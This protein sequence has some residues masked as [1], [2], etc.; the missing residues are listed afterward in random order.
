M[1]ARVGRQT[2]NVNPALLVVS[3]RGDSDW[4][5]YTT[6]VAISFHY[7]FGFTGSQVV[8]NTPSL[9]NNFGI[10]V[11]VTAAAAVVA[12]AGDTVVHSV[13][14]TAAAR[15]AAACGHNTATVAAIRAPVPT[16]ASRVLRRRALVVV[17][18]DVIPQS[19]FLS[20][21]DACWRI[22]ERLRARGVRRQE[23]QCRNAHPAPCR[24][25]NQRRRRARAARRAREL[26]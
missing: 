13:R 1:Y 5:M 26:E 24:C 16:C 15:I 18:C 3:V 25:V 6:R 9:A 17:V 11:A 19:R 22:L 14:S 12:F 4:L 7:T 2:E 23:N 20:P 10:A 8:R 21:Y